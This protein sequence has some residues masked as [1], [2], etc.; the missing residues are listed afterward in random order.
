MWGYVSGICVVP[1]NTKEGDGA[2]IN[3][4]EANNAKIIT[5]I[6]NSVEHY[7]GTQLVKYKTT[8]KVLDHL[9]WL[10]TQLNFAKQYQLEN[11]IW[12]LH[13]KNMSV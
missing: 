11:D 12:A 13:K 3:A 6:N 1:K 10:F 4:W 2:S 5:W 7:I 9:Q 8:K